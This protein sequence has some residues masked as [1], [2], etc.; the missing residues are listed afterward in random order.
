MEVEEPS[1][2]KIVEILSSVDQREISQYQLL[3]MLDPILAKRLH[4][5]DSRK[6]ERNLQLIKETKRKQ[7]DLM[8]NKKMEDR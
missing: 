7:S 6:I 3:Q 8:L 5:N 2:P 1:D 4:P